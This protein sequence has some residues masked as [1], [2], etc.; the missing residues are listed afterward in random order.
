MA[1]GHAAAPGPWLPGALVAV[2]AAAAVVTS[3]AGGWRDPVV[4]GTV[5]G[6]A[7]MAAFRAWM[8]RHDGVTAHHTLWA[9][10]RTDSVAELY[11]RGPFGGIRWHALVRTFTPHGPRPAPGDL[12]LFFDAGTEAPPGS[13]TGDARA[14]GVCRRAARELWGVPPRRD[15]SWRPVFATPDGVVIQYRVGATG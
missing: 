13:G 14:C 15:P 4:T 10:G 7:Q 9:D 2:V 1:Y 12:V 6:R 3:T 11:R 8:H 5:N